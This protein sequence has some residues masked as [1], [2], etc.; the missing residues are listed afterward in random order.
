MVFRCFLAFLFSFCLFSSPLFPSGYILLGYGCNI[1][2]PAARVI[3]GATGFPHEL[4]HFFTLRIGTPSTGSNCC[5]APGGEVPIYWS[6]VP[7]FFSVEPFGPILANMPAG[8]SQSLE[9]MW[10]EV[11]KKVSFG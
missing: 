5:G 11:Q 10:E 4:F 7:S 1:I 3:K 6:A 2:T 9:A 8:K